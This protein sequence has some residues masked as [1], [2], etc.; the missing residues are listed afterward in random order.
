MGN[1]NLASSI[2]IYWVFLAALIADRLREPVIGPKLAS[3]G[4]CSMYISGTSPNFFNSFL[5]DVKVSN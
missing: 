5:I 4:V 2:G 1:A 3:L